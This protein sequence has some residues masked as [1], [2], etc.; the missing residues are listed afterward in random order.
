MAERAAR[1]GAKPDPAER[2]PARVAGAVGPP[3]LLA[4]ETYHLA[5]STTWGIKLLRDWL[6]SEGGPNTINIGDDAG[7]GRMYI[8]GAAFFGTYDRLRALLERLVLEPLPPDL[9]YLA[10]PDEIANVVDR[11]YDQS[12]LRFLEAL[13]KNLGSRTAQ[14]LTVNLERQAV[15]QQERLL[16][17]NQ[18]A[19][20]AA[21]TVEA[22][23]VV[24]PETATET[25]PTGTES[26]Q[27][28]LS[29]S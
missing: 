2:L 8:E 15:I 21:M 20:E 28:S 5:V 11:A 26:P 29:A 13:A 12:G 14:L 10:Q 16:R 27:P 18:L 1:N 9:E 23:A 7:I 17:E 6:T 3:V 22:T 4:G 19:L 25:T 24:L